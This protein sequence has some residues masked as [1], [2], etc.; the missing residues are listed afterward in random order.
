LL[1][2]IQRSRENSPQRHRLIIHKQ[3]LSL[4]AQVAYRGPTWLDRVDPSS[5]TPYGLGAD[6]ASAIERRH[7]VRRGFGIATEDRQARW[8]LFELERDS[9]AG[10]FVKRSGQ[11]F[12]AE[13]P[14]GFRGQARDFVAPGGASYAIISDGQRFVVIRTANAHHW[15][16]RT[17]TVSRDAKGRPLLRG[18][19]DRD[20]GA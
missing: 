15:N 13:A 5:L 4:S 14:T 3:P 10:Q 11:T 20:L 17:V 19:P 12:V 9:V 18:A 16:G 1:E 7:E 2:Q 6:I 8:R